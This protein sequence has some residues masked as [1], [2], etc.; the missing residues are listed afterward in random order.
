MLNSSQT[1][2]TSDYCCLRP[3][4]FGVTRKLTCRTGGGGV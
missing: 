3:V 2:L 1:K 4:E